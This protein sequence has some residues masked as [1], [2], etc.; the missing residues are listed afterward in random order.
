MLQRIKTTV[1]DFATKVKLPIAVVLLSNTEANTT[2][3]EDTLNEI[4][5]FSDYCVTCCKFDIDDLIRNMEC[6]LDFLAKQ[7]REPPSMELNTLWSYVNTNLCEDLWRRMTSYTKWNAFYK[8]C[9]QSPNLVIDLYNDAVDHL[10]RIALDKSRFEYSKFPEEFEDFLQ[11]P[12][13]EVLP[14][15]WR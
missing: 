8:V 13:P 1:K 7:V 5:A 11:N 10:C 6:S 2:E 4:E 9:L 14:C 3:L 15:D 12:A